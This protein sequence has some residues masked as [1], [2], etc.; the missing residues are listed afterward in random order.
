MRVDRL[1][2][3]GVRGAALAADG[4]ALDALDADRLQVA[5]KHAVHEFGG[6]A[7]RDVVV[8]Q[9]LVQAGDA[10][11]DGGDDAQ[12]VADQQHGQVQLDAELL[13]SVAIGH[14]S[15]LEV[16]AAPADMMP[17]DAINSDFVDQIL[18]TASQAYDLDYRLVLAIIKVESNFRNDAVSH[19]G[20]RGLLQI[21][22]SLAKYI[23]KDAGGRY[24]GVHSLHDADNNI[25][26]GVYHLSTLLDDFKTVSAALHAYNVGA[27]KAKKKLFGNNEP[28]TR[29]TSHVLKEYRK[30]IEVL[31]ESD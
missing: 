25:R 30:N 13:Q 11:A 23:A 1:R 24:D 27:N 26:L 31:P 14:A 28:K 5:G 10:V 12:V 16:V 9:R 21:K 2:G 18:R 8:M 20:A 17:V 29:F 4:P 19:R 3:V 15:G 6:N 22:P 7:P